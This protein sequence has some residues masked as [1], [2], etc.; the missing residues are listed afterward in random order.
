MAFR[1]VKIF[2]RDSN[3]FWF[4]SIIAIIISLL[5]MRIPFFWDNI[6]I[7]E[8]ASAYYSGSLT[9]FELPARLDYGVFTLY[10]YYLAVIWSVF[11][12]SLLISHLAFIPVIIGILYEIKKISIRFI[13]PSYLFLLYL[14]LLFDPAFLT[15]CLLMGYDIFMLYF[16]LWAIRNLLEKKYLWY[17]VSLLLLTLIS[18]RA[19]VFVFCLFFIQVMVTY[20]DKDKIK[21]RHL[22]LYLPSI[23]FLLFWFLRHYNITGWILF[24]NENNPF[25]NIN[26]VSML[27][28]HLGF[29]LWKLSDSGRIIIWLFCLIS[30]FAGLRYIKFNKKIKI[31]L[32][33]ICVPLFI[34][35]IVM[36]LISNPIGHKYFMQTFVFLDILAVYFIQKISSYRKQIILSVAIVLCLFAGN[37]MLYPQKYGNAWDTSL[38]ILPYFKAER[39]MQTFILKHKIDPTEVYTAFPLTVNNRFSNLQGDFAYNEFKAS[40]MEQYKFILFSN[41]MNV[42][43]LSPYYKVK[44]EWKLICNITYCQIF[45]SLYRSP[46]IKR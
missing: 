29:L 19:I 15:Q 6:T 37:F 5:S 22:L 24:T 9:E 32:V 20:I 44:S 12:K 21:L 45:V 25:R 35:G 40:E 1:F 26:N 17:S 30:F 14:F 18:V 3:S 27:I 34:Y 28:R 13:N 8:I 7:S 36:V 42:A 41:I 23:V 39:Q 10:S 2:F 33:T 38:K 11:G 31:L 4:F 46:A 43:D 16:I